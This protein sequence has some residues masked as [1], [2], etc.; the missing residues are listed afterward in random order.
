MKKRL[1]LI[2]G[3][4]KGIGMATA[5]NIL[6]N[7]PDDKLIGITRSNTEEL[8]NLYEK[9]PKR[10]F[11]KICDISDYDKFDILLDQLKEN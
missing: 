11:I 10:F 8:S 3:C 2:T 5:E 6:R 1:G 4:G 9:Y 7:F